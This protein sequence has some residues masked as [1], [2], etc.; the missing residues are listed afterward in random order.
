MKIYCISDI[1]GY[2]NELKAALEHIDLLGDGR[3]ALLGDYI[4][5]GP[6]S[7]EV[8]RYIRD[9]QCQHGSEKVIVLRGNHEEAFLEWL[10]TY[11]GPYTGEPDKYGMIP[12][13]DWLEGDE[14]FGAFRT[15]VTLEQWAFF[16]KVLPTLS[17]DSRNIAA[18]QMVLAADSELIAW[19][20]E[21][22]YYYETP[23]QI[24]V[25]A[26]VEEESGEW[27]PWATPEHVFVGKYPAETGPF[28]KDIIAGHVGTS[29]LAE[30]PAYHGVWW[31]RQ[32]HYYI[33]GSI[34]QGGQLNILAW[35][36]EQGY[37]QWNDGWRKI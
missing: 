32:N 7:G 4:D 6:Q 18:A 8:L 9:L 13:N 15:L 19:L 11:G 14:D 2:L 27:W 25:H 33:D 31:D 34:Q 36:E 1:H 17:E 35:D 16:Q 22:P 5:Y 23:R 24:F 37:Q 3:L 10:S 12:W 20:R 29:R 30:T 26:G 28:Y 21:L